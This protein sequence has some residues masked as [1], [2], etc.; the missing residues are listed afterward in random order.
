MYQYRVD[1]GNFQVRIVREARGFF[2]CCFLKMTEFYNLKCAVDTNLLTG[3]LGRTIESSRGKFRKMCLG[4]VRN[5]LSK[6][7]LLLPGLVEP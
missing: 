3:C 7:V 1:T 4:S 5:E 2:L 6:T